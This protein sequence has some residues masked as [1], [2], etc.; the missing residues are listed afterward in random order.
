MCSHFT[1]IYPKKLPPL[2]VRNLLKKL[3]IPRKWQHFLRIKRQVTIN[4]HYRS[5]NRLVKGG[6]KINLNLNFVHDHQQAYTASGS[7][8]DVI[9]EDRT[10]IVINKPSGQKT[11][12]NSKETNTALNDCATYLGKSPYVVHRL[13]MLTSGLLLIAK[14]PT[15]VPILN[16]Q[17]TTKLFQ[18]QYRAIVDHAQFLHRTGTIDLPIGRDPDDLRKRRVTVTGRKAIT[19]YRCLKR[20]GQQALLALKL[21][22]GRTHQIRV[23]LAAIGCPVVGDPLYNP[24]YHA[25]QVLQLTAVKLAFI[26]PFSFTRKIITLPTT[27]KK[28]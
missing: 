19:H 22:T 24:A 7:K 17:L 2:S 18:R 9:Y 10:V 25:G 8:P 23:H 16:R 12:P 28:G 11:H 20:K 15:V 27:R 21:E 26:K 5:F 1:L 13:D 6:E 14:S 3:F 4:G